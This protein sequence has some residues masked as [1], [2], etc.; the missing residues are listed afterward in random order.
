MMRRFNWHF[1][2][3][4]GIQEMLNDAQKDWDRQAFT[5]PTKKTTDNIVLLC[6]CA[7]IELNK[8]INELQGI[9]NTKQYTKG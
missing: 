2:K 3:I 7:V 9:K 6:S 5:V 4:A 8:L 1:D